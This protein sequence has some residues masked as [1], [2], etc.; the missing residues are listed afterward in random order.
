M[1]FEPRPLK[2]NVNVIWEASMNR[3]KLICALTI[4]ALIPA[5][6]FADA[7]KVGVTI[8]ETGPAASLGI[9][10]RKTIPLLP[11]EIAGQKIEYIVLDD[12][13][14]PTKAVANARKLASDENADVIVGSS[15]SPSSLAL[16]EVA[17]EIKIPLI[18]LAASAKIVS[19]MDDKRKWVFKTPQNDSLMAAAIAEHMAAAG[20]KT[21]GFIGFSDAYGDGW[22]AEMK[23]ALAARNIELADVERYARP[24]TSVTGQVLKLMAANP[25]VIL[26]AGAGTPAALPQKTLRERGYKGVIYQ[27]HGAAN[28]DFLRVGGKDVEGTILPAGPILVAGQLPDTNP[29]KKIGVEYTRNYEAANGTGSI[30]TFGAHILDAGILLTNAIPIALKTAKP[31]TPEFRLALRDALEGLKEVNCS[32][33]VITM[34]PTDHAGHDARARLMVTIRNGQWTLTN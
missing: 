9:A 23:I 12:G 4:A 3:L 14:D 19:P 25:D 1:V 17:S 8:A 2:K 27:T 11:Q 24:D 31:G 29:L 16:V 34:T 32:H 28:A 33:G 26:V 18:S 20:V 30:T 13:T 15:T 5:A 22:L 10:Q 21:A 6:A 7:V